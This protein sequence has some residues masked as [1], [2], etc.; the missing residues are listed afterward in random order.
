M[1]RRTATERAEC[2]NLREH[3]PAPDGYVAWHAWAARMNLTHAQHP[4]PGCGRLKI[5]L[6]RAPAAA[7]EATS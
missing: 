6:P 1:G 5:W 4:C 3:T 7:T 2:P